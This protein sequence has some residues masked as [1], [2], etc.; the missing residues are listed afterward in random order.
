VKRAFVDTSG[1]VAALI[2]EDQFHRTA[3]SLLQESARGAWELVTTNAVV[4]EAYTVL[5]TRARDGRHVALRFLDVIERGMC[6]VARIEPTDE[7]RAIAVLRGH[8]D[9]AYSFCDALSFAVMERLGL[10]DVI[11]FDRD[12]RSYGRFTLL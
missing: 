1:F 7:T 11:A 8:D 5:R 10:Q 12:F 2:A 4:F 6:T 3:V 9:K